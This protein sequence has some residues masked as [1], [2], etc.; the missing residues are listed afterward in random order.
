[1]VERRHDA[2]AGRDH[3]TWSVLGKHLSQAFVAG[4][5]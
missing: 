1:M 4:G 5:L 2:V 3:N